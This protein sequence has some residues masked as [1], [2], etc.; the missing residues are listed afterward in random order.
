M[1]G[2]IENRRVRLSS[3]TP[4]RARYDAAQTTSENRAHWLMA[5]A[6]SASS[7]ASP[8]VR[9]TLRNRA[10]YE[11][12]NNCYASGML[13]TFACEVIGTGPQLQMQSGDD[14]AD[15][16]VEN[17]FWDWM[18]ETGFSEKLRTML[19]AQVGHG[20]GFGV[21][22]TNLRLE[23]PVKLDLRLY[24]ADQFAAPYMSTSPVTLMSDGI[25]YDDFGNPAGYT[26]LKSHPGDLLTIL[27]PNDFEI[28]PADRVIHLYRP[29][30]AGQ[31]RGIPWVTPALPLC[32]QMRRFTLAVLAASEN[33]ANAWGILSTDNPA[34]NPDELEPLD[35]FPLPRNSLLT[36]PA[37]TNLKGLK[38]E[39]PATT[40]EMFKRC[41]VSEFARCLLM[42]YGVAAGDSSAYNFS[43]GK[44]DRKGWVRATR[45]EHSRLESI[46]IERI[47]S[48]WWQEMRLID[49]PESLPRAMRSLRRPSRHTWR[50]DGDEPIDPLKESNAKGIKLQY[51]MTTLASELSQDG[52]DWQEVMAQRAKE[53]SHAIS[54]CESNGI[55][56]Q[57]APLLY[58]GIQLQSA[59]IGEDDEVSRAD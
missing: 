35:E 6:L 49:G 51:G 52:S 18:Q 41:L 34:G 19:I 58:G 46:V 4:V 24:E 1:S 25:V 30:R 10:R 14:G 57:L 48:A 16:A 29:E 3:M 21:L 12:D 45:V 27:G 37:G 32:A 20:E 36:M 40:Y 39:Q 55:D 15:S 44:L 9:R 31:L 2:R 43:S 47:F 59:P 38:A 22:A 33:L 23:T 17:A 54:L 8:S 42:P 13:R 5:D 56:I 26:M 11:I 28:M 53:I 50:W 7:S